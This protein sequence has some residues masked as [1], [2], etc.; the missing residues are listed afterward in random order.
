MTRLKLLTLMAI[1][2]LLIVLH[3]TVSVQA[4]SPHVIIGKATLNGA[5]APAGTMITAMVDGQKAGSAE[6]MGAEGKFE[7]PI[8]MGPGEDITFMIGDVMAMEKVPWMQGGAMMQ[9][10]TASSANSA[11]LF[12]PHV[13]VGTASIDGL[14]APEGT[15]IV[16]L[17]DEKLAGS[18]VTGAD[19]KFASL[20]V[21]GPGSKVT[22]RIASY[23]AAQE[24]TWELGGLDAVHLTASSSDTAAVALKPLGDKL[25]RVFKFDNATKTWSFY[26][27]REEFTEINTLSG[28]VS[29]EAYWVKVTETTTAILNGRVVSLTCARGNCWNH[30]VW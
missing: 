24:L 21:K 3:G 11:G 27:P 22:F 5:P 20:M 13:F 12:P 8:V 28:L 26:D 2:A 14:P 16:A 1:M 18:V 15:A 6:V 25:V 4:T 9:D 23:D 7:T 19:G 30:V 29:G 17:V 10:L